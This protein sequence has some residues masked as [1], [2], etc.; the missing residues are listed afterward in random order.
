LFRTCWFIESTLSEII[1]T[2]SIRTKMRF[3]RSRPSRILLV[4]S[5]V[6]GLLTV[7]LPYSQFN[8]VFE[9]Y[10]PTPFLLSLIFGILLLYFVVVELVKHFF[11]KKTH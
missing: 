8:T 6:F 10:P 2:F 4:S 11:H 3:Y 1:V 7:L 9:F 5:V